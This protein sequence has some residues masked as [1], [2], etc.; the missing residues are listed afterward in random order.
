M[1]AIVLVLQERMGTF[2]LIRSFVIQQ[3]VISGFR[4]THHV[5]LVIRPQDVG[6]LELSRSAVGVLA[7]GSTVHRLGA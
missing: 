1:A 2:Q 3:T 4:R 5:L 7:L 6:R